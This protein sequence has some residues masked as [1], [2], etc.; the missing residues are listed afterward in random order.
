M[1]AVSSWLLSITC[2]ILLSVL[3][4]FVLPD[5]QV[6]KFIKVVF[7]F[8]ILLVIILPLP[9]LIRSDF[10][11]SN[12]MEQETS[13]QDDFLEQVNLDK[14]NSLSESVNTQISNAGIKNV[15]VAIGGNIFAKT[16]EIYS[17]VADLRNIEYDS[18]FTNKNIESAKAVI[19][20]IIRKHEAL[21]GVEVRFRE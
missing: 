4:E 16:L 6:N 12:Y 9:T 14:L 8:V 11:L 19:I 10:D 1:S 13:L 17:I 18:S 5:G 20:Q 3:A 15:E 7:S 21:N 2:V